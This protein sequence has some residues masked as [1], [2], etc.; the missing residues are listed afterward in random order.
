M[1]IKT[2]SVADLKQQLDN[3]SGGWLIDVRTVEE[4]ERL[5]APEVK[6]VILHTDIT[7]TPD[8]L[9]ADKSTPIYLICRSGNRS[10]KA[11]KLLMDVGFTEVFNVTGGML[12]WLEHGF[13][14]ESGRGVLDSHST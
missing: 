2:I 14:V 10:G 13:P 6:R 7:R 11:A 1:T 5:H 8:L 3:R 4:Y 12:S 9:P